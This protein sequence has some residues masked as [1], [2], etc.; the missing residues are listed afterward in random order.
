MGHVFHLPTARPPEFLSRSAGLP[1]LEVRIS[2][3]KL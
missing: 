2:G 1:G 3:Q